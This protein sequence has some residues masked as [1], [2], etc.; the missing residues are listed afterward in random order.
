MRSEKT[1]QLAVTGGPWDPA[2][3]W[4]AK[5]TLLDEVPARTL[6]LLH[7]VPLWWRR[8]AS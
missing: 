8:M 3:V 4:G 2:R 7:E 1:A 5:L 6:M